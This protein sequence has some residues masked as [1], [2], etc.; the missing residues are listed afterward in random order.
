[1]EREPHDSAAEPAE[2]DGFSREPAP[3]VA[4]QD[5][6]PDRKVREAVEPELIE[7]TVAALPV[8]Q[9]AHRFFSLVLPSDILADNCAVEARSDNP[10]DGFQRLLD[11]KRAREIARYIDAGFG[12]V[13]SAIIL[14]AQSRARLKY[15]RKTGFVS[16]R[17]DPRAFLIIDGQHR[18][19]GFKLAKKSVSA[20]VVVYNDLTRAQECQLF[21]DIN[22]KQK[23][24]PQELLLDIRRLSLAETEAEALLHD[25][26][27]LFD[28][29]EDSA[30]R[31]RLS[32]HERR[33][34]FI[35][36]VTFNAALRSIS[37]AL[38]GASA[39]HV[40]GLLNLYYRVCISGLLMHDAQDNIVNSALF[41]ALTLLFPDVAERVSDRH[42][43]EMTAKKLED[44]LLPMFRRLRKSELPKP[45]AGHHALHEHY[46]KTLSSG[47]LLKNWFFM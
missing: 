1:M 24:V 36:R 15:D 32:A 23:P 5:N 43:A 42:G 26:F 37:R 29:R 25:V 4:D 34:G 20:P 11:K 41:K 10:Q 6:R 30:L 9:G 12:A 46:R 22:T 17:R 2:A 7:I 16:F 3:L 21:M 38:D 33:R 35:T 28:T 14:S 39:E 19:F 31:G 18:V 44:V 27:D 8:V 45:G 40:Y 47:L 13:P